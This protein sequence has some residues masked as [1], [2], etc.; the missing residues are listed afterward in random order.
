VA[1]EVETNEPSE[2]SDGVWGPGKR[3]L[4]TGLVL[5]ITLVGFEAL[6]IATVM[7][8]VS[9]D[10]ND[11]GLYGWVFSAFFLGTLVGIVFAG[12]AADRVGP[13]QPITVGL[14][15]F[16]AGLIAGGAAPTMLLLV[17]ARAIQGLGAG[18]IPAIAYVAIGRAYR[19]ALQPRMFAVVSTA[20]VLPAVLGPTPSGAIADA[21]GWRW[22]FFGLLPFVVV[23]AVMTIPALRALGPPGGDEPADR[24]IDAL[25]VALG[26]GLVLGGASARNP[27]VLVPLLVAGFVIGGPAF[28]RLVPAG[29]LRLA[30]G[31]P[32]AIALRGIITFAFFGTDAFVSLT[33]TSVHGVSATVAGI[34]L[35]AAALTWT[36]GA[37][38]QE[39]RVRINGP[40]ALV[41]TGASII[42]V[43]VAMM[44]ATAAFDVPIVFGIV[45]W[46]VGGLGMGLAYAPLSLIMLSEAAPGAEG[47]ASAALTLSETLG[48]ALGTGAT[49]AIVAAGDA[50]DWANGRALTIAFAV[51][52]AVAVIAIGA[53]VRLPS[54]VALHER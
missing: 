44:I 5:T 53:A 38:I 18:A 16:A 15:L 49:G 42:A 25:L 1:A 6:A 37:W 45:A 52:C 23:A 33:M 32:A 41:R 31:M 7:P 35:T 51:C 54:A 14:V 20:W 24:R 47:A 8:V 27:L 19:P 43:G 26:A 39:R 11:V 9:K 3:A 22:V 4:T 2:P 12:R 30:P 46:A 13:A 34:P 29:T 28:K 50:L 17:V 36:A 10:L 21:I 48:V 40:R